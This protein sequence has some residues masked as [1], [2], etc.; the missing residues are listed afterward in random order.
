[1]RRALRAVRLSNA[2]ALK[3]HFNQFA[4]GFCQIKRSADA[5]GTER[6]AGFLELQCHLLDVGHGA[7]P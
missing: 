5:Q 3:V 6:R 4:L 7:A 2:L 1:M